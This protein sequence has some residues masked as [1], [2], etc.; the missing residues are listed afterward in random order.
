MQMPKNVSY[1]VTDPKGSLIIECGKMLAQGG[2]R[3]K[4]LGFLRLLLPGRIP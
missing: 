2:Y 3:V 4:V 1:I